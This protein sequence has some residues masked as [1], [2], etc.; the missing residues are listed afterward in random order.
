MGALSSNRKRG[1][2]YYTCKFPFLN[3]PNLNNRIDSRI[4]KKSKTSSSMQLSAER[5]QSSTSASSRL[6]RYPEPVNQFRRE[7]HAPC[8]SFKFGLF[9]S[10]NRWS[11]PKIARIGQEDSADVKGN[12]LSLRYDQAKNSAIGTLRYLKKD[13]E[14]IDVDSE[15]DKSDVSVD[16][17][18]EEVEVLEDGREWLSVVSDQ[19]SQ[20]TSG[21]ERNVPELGGKVVELNFQQTSPP[22]VSDSMN[23]DMKMEKAEKMLNS[24][25]LNRELDASSLPIHKMLLET[26]EMRSPKLNSLSFQIELAEKRRA[27]LR[28]RRTVKKSEDEDV[29][30][31]YFRE[32]FVPLTMEEET[33]ISRAFS[34]SS[35]YG[36]EDEFVTCFE[37]GVF[38]CDLYDSHFC[39]RKVLVTHE[40]SNIEITGGVL[41]CLRRGAWLNDE[42]E[43]AV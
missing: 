19:R 3:S 27:I 30:Q 21:V 36:F 28:I 15:T 23:A 41:Q 11:R 40:K 17:S 37:K 31:D 35:R 24:L 38:I 14:V 42:M 2:D 16:S 32:S 5:P 29:H 26:A 4:S 8:R 7:V 10:L 22:M 20:E 1:V 33:E 25:S 12:G 39:R 34:N 6:C 9:R 13:K 18:S 43:F